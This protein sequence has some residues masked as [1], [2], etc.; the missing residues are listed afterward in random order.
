MTIL[1]A[2]DRDILALVL[3]PRPNLTRKGGPALLSLSL[4]STE[5]KSLAHTYNLLEEIYEKK[6]IPASEER[7]RNRY[8]RTLNNCGL[9]TGTPTALTLTTA[10]EDLRSAVSAAT[11]AGA[12]INADFWSTNGA[13]LEL[14]VIRALIERMKSGEVVAN[15]FLEAWFN[16]QT[17]I[18][19]V[20]ASEQDALLANENW[21]LRMFQINSA[22]W[23][24]ARFFRLKPEERE[25]F[26]AAH[27]KVLKND[28][29]PETDPI[30][31][32]ATLYKRA[33]N[34]YQSDVRFRIKNFLSAFLHLQTELGP[35]FPRL[36]RQLTLSRSVSASVAASGPTSGGEVPTAGITPNAEPLPY[37]HQIIISGC[38]GSGK[39][40]QLEAMIKD[41][42]AKVFRTQFHP[43]TSYYDFVGAYRPQPV[44]EGT[45]SG[46]VELDST[47]FARGKPMID[48]RFVPGPLTKALVYA[49]RHPDQ[50]VVVQIEEL[51]RGN[52]AAIFGDVLQ[53]LD[54]DG[55]GWSRYAVAPVVEH[56]A[57]IRSETGVALDE[58]RLP[59]NLYL[60]ATMNSADQGVYPIDSAFR[61]RWSYTYMGYSIACKYEGEAR[62][63]TYGGKI[64][65]WDQ[66]R[67]ELNKRLVE[68]NIHEDKLVGPYFLTKP[69]L[70]SPED[71]LQKLFLYLWDDVLRFRQHELFVAKSFSEVAIQWSHGAGT[72]LNIADRLHGLALESSTTTSDVAA[73]GGADTGAD[74]D[75]ASSSDEEPTSE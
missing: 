14:P 26:F 32:V 55:K 40:F 22:G 35:N 6:L 74:T 5:L 43:E 45:L 44:Y 28:F 49:L 67:S 3:E 21:L 71:V 47:I 54:R 59:S 15:A 61:R 39:S 19:C 24:V 18:D 1:L 37:P 31:Q 10:G 56:L 4:Y 7:T 60:W 50:N 64:Y 66:F 2:E 57:H 13:S 72:P 16:A 25:R 51:N 33:A 75:E 20:P 27:S 73:S 8:F 11:S 29:T 63:I 36:S 53:L 70:V 42:G 69:Q 58:L 68:L 9:V 34:Q 41:S 30:D 52:P 38:P 17:F 12:A 46:L 23:E 62:K 48:Y 65:D